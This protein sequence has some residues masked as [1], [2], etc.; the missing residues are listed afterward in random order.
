MA[1]ATEEIIEALSRHFSN[2]IG[3]LE[4]VCPVCHVEAG[5]TV[6]GPQALLPFDGQVVQLQAPILP[7]VVLLCTHCSSAL[8]VPWVTLKQGLEASRG[9]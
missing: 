9:Q 4:P 3:R 8:L 1:I 6:L 2:K 7:I 5:W